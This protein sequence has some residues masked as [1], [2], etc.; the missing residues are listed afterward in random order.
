MQLIN[1]Y[2]KI[3]KNHRYKN[4]YIYLEWRSWDHLL[5]FLNM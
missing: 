3:L 5:D 2:H 4:R 1:L